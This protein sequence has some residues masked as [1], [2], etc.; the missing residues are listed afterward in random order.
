MNPPPRKTSTQLLQ[1]IG[2]NLHPEKGL[3]YIEA[4]LKHGHVTALATVAQVRRAA[5]AIVVACAIGVTSQGGIATGIG[6]Y[7][8]PSNPGSAGAGAGLFFFLP[9]RL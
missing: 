7:H 5:D 4:I 9:N 6:K 2:V 1:L 8:H 3:C